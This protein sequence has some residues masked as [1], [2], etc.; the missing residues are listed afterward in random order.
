MRDRTCAYRE[1]GRDDAPHLKPGLDLST[2]V[3]A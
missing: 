3:S 1:G 2:E